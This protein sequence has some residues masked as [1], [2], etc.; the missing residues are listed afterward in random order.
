MADPTAVP[1]LEKDAAEKILESGFAKVDYVA[2]RDA[3]T[4]SAWKPERQGRVL[5]AAWL[6]KTRLIDNIA[7]GVKRK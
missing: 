5:V 1:T 4:L 2:V 6:G 7:V 3:E